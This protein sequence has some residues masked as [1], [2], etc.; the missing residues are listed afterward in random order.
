M[1]Q[2]DAPERADRMGE[3]ITRS[4]GESRRVKQRWGPVA[5]AAR[6]AIRPQAW[7]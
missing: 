4:M 3:D 7:Q 2:W 1:T 5:V 6:S